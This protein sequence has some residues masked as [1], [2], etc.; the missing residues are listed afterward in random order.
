MNGP[1]LDPPDPPMTDPVW[2]VPPE[3]IPNLDELVVEDGR[4]VESIFAERQQRLLTS[5][6]NTTWAGPG[7]GRSFVAL[8]HVGVF[9][10]AKE[11]PLVPDVLLSLDVALG[12]NV[13]EK[14]NRSYFLWELGKPPDV[15]VE[16]V[17]DRRGGESGL[18]QR[19]YAR[20]GVPYYVLF[21]PQELLKGGV[22]RTFRLSGGSYEPLAR[23]FFP[24]VGLGMTLWQGTFERV[25][26]C[27]LRWCDEQGTLIPSAEEAATAAE[28]RALSAE[29]RADRLA[30]RLRELGVDPEA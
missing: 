29:E 22:L 3:V 26:A 15:V 14:E 27:W 2:E 12:A 23:H 5:P 21:D 11:P 4:P 6:L 17:S 28:Q 25:T 7:E 8:A 1:P 24:N 16:I 13:F 30:A 18:K 19:Q 9:F 10:Q 20:I